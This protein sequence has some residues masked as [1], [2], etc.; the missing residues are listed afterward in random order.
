ME[1][2]QC[3][4]SNVDGTNGKFE[5]NANFSENQ[6]YSQLDQQ[7]AYFWPATTTLTAAPATLTSNRYDATPADNNS[8]AFDCDSKSLNGGHHQ[9]LPPPSYTN[10]D[11]Q[12]PING[13]L[14]ELYNGTA[15]VPSHS[16]GQR[17]SNNNSLQSEFSRVNG[18]GKI[19][20]PVAM[21][22]SVPNWQQS[23]GRVSQ[24]QTITAQAIGTS[25]SVILSGSIYITSP[26]TPPSP[27]SLN[28]QGSA[29]KQTKT[30]S[31]V[32]ERQI[33][34]SD[35]HRLTRATNIQSTSGLLSYPT[36]GTCVELPPA[37]ADDTND[38]NSMRATTLSSS[39]SITSTKAAN[40][41]IAATGPPIGQD[42]EIASTFYTYN[43]SRQEPL[44]P[45]Q[46]AQF[47]SGTVGIQYNNNMIVNHHHHHLNRFPLIEESHLNANNPNNEHP[48]GTTTQSVAPAT[49]A[50]VHSQQLLENQ[51]HVYQHPNQNQD[52]QRQ[53]AT[54]ESG[55]S[56]ATHFT[57]AHY[58]LNSMA[59]Y[60]TSSSG[61]YEAASRSNNMAAYQHPVVSTHQRNYYSK[62]QHP[63]GSSLMLDHQEGVLD[64]FEQQPTTAESCKF[65]PNSSVIGP[66]EQQQQQ[67]HSSSSPNKFPSPATTFP[68]PLQSSSAGGSSTSSCS[69][70]LSAQL[71]YDNHISMTEN[72]GPTNHW[73]PQ[74]QQQNNEDPIAASSDSLAAAAANR[75]NLFSHNESNQQQH[76]H[77]HAQASGGQFAPLVSQ[78]GLQN[79]HKQADNNQS[80]RYQSD[81]NQAIGSTRYPEQQQ[82]QQQQQPNQL[83]HECSDYM[84]QTH[85]QLNLQQS[86]ENYAHHQKVFNQTASHFPITY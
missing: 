8:N 50:T 47:N 61:I 6:I 3:E 79:M 80:A 83:Q 49:Q 30:T 38:I 22:S 39:S 77:R 48:L 84:M 85:R 67:Q 55:P 64:S 59:A 63:D 73:T 41:A 76:G 17:N 32:H 36:T 18:E 20:N 45:L 10:C 53:Q 31:L 19:L 9:T 71:T 11:Y 82:Q 69:S 13:N 58:P 54:C 60:E 28:E 15:I 43:H 24:Q 66:F 35:S 72:G 74:Q 86:V 37:C 5:C 52:Q 2:G 21:D 75:L 56:S 29:I 26:I 81:Y 65:S 16:F 40:L 51:Q 44:E 12:Q 33:L 34:T 7:A 42:N 68:H 70:L 27:S 4:C 14:S 25:S 78:P 23:S 1:L 57:M 46:H 62:N